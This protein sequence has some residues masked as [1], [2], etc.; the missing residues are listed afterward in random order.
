M[1][2]LKIK[3]YENGEPY[4]L[5]EGRVKNH[6]CCDCKLVHFIFCEKAKKGKVTM[7]WYRDDYQTNKLRKKTGR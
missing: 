3:D 2:P 4:I 7:F 1:K 5:Q 6:V